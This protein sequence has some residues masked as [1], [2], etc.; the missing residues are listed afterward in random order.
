MIEDGGERTDVVGGAAVRRTRG[1]THIVGESEEQAAAQALTY[2][3]T[4]NK[5]LLPPRD[6]AL[7]S[8]KYVCHY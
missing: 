5:Q 6:R 2:E 1:S 3:L 8:I 4:F 7:T